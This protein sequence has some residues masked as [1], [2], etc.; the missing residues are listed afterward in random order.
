MLSKR[1]L[2]ALALAP[3]K[4]TLT[5]ASAMPSKPEKVGSER[6]PE[7]ANDEAKVPAVVPE[8]NDPILDQL[9]PPFAL[10]SQSWFVKPVDVR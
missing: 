1:L 7:V 10:Y 9:V 6:T 5:R 8:A 3:V 4:V 2:P